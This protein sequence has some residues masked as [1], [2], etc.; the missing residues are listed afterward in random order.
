MIMNRN[1]L[2][3]SLSL[4]AGAAYFSAVALAHATGV[5]IPGLFIYFNVNS[6]PYQ[7][8]IIA[9]LAF[10]WSTFFYIAADDPVNRPL[11]VRAILLSGV[12]AIFGLGAINTFDDFGAV[13]P[14]VSV[15]PFWAQTIFLLFYLVWLTVFYKKSLRC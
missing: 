4:K 15:Q 1:G 12:V 9:F 2:V 6:Y 13:S 8:H 3:L 5:K 14:G 11:P 7:D 10:G